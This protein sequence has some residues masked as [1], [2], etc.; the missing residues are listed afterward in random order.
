M[1]K[2][3]CDPDADARRVIAGLATLR[4]ALERYVKVVKASTDADAL[5]AS[6]VVDAYE[7][8]EALTKGQE[9]PIWRFRP[10][11]RNTRLPTI[12][13]TL[14]RGLAVGAARAYQAESGSISMRAAC[15]V[16]AKFCS[17]ASYQL[18]GDQIRS[19]SNQDGDAGCAISCTNEILAQAR[20][21]AEP[22]ALSERIL[23]V[24]RGLIWQLSTPNV[25]H[26][27]R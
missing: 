1:P 6:G 2:R 21:R 22:A 24:S 9:H 17:N 8:L 23:E 10:G 13:E 11:T 12:V 16:V 15:D 3:R 5:P 25:V 4:A 26:I 27:P 7:I 20:Q 14:R 18:T 19:W